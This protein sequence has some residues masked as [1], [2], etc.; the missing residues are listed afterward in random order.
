MGTKWKGWTA[1]TAVKVFAFMLAV[2][3]AFVFVSSVYF[4]I[5][6]YVER[7]V[8]P[9]VVLADLTVSGYDYFFD[10]NIPF[11]EYQ[12][13]VVLNGKNEA[14]IREVINFEWLNDVD[15]YVLY[16]ENT[17]SNNIESY[18][19]NDEEAASPGFRQRVENSILNR[20]ITDLANA[21][22]AL[23]TEE[24]LLFYIS[25]GEFVFTN[26]ENAAIE[27][28]T[29]CPVYRLFEGNRVIAKSKTS[30][31]DSSYN[32]ANTNIKIYVAY[33]N[34]TV[35]SYISNM[36]ISQKIYIRL[37]F[38]AGISVIVAIASIIVLIAGAGRRRYDNG[39]EIHFTAFDWLFLD[40]GIAALLLWEIFAAVVIVDG[41][42]Y[43]ISYNTA[44]NRALFI[45]ALI[46]VLAGIP[47]LGWICSFAKRAKSGN[48]FRHTIAY[49]LFA[50]CVR[51]VRSLW[52][53]VPLTVKAVLVSVVSFIVMAVFVFTWVDGMI[54]LAF[55]ISVGIGILLL[56]YG[57]R[58]RAI[59]IGAQLAGE[60]FYDEPIDVKGGEL[61]KIANSINHISAGINNAVAERMKS[62]RLKTEL[63]TN[64]SHDIRTPLTSLITYT[65][66]LKNEGLDCEKAPEYL[67]VL[68]QKSQRLKTLT[69]E[70]FEASKAA[71]GNIDAN[72]ET[73]NLHAFI[74][75][76]LGEL[77]VRVQS[78]GL[79]FR[80]NI[81][82]TSLVM[83][84]G[85]LLW[86]VMENLL[87]NVFKYAQP[88]SR[89]Y[90]DA[91]SDGDCYRLDVKNMSKYS[92][93]I[94]P[95]ELTE[96]FKRGDEARSGDGSGLGL[97]IVQSFVQAQ[98][99]R[100]VLAVD[101]DLFKATVYLPSVN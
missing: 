37:L 27:T 87:S 29:A 21:Q 91:V 41:G 89:V 56:L 79:D 13:S 28:F 58:L 4:M 22:T 82:E 19:Y 61:G 68:I 53:G 101:G 84:D 81:P 9:E 80:L 42:G 83:A 26:A 31:Y 47:L 12:A 40:I 43:L 14:N 59:E 54:V 60:G 10:N 11:A 38:M 8:N 73:L 17:S 100:F 51:F 64:V 16:A 99:G 94:D 72:P 57:R 46:A 23:T 18:Y 76:V 45:I 35:S 97:S 96:R 48:P 75:Q 90:I 74:E 86:R 98:C 6:E 24:G 7:E 30:G 95:S 69:D 3:S 49:W 92:L 62:E 33:D 85:K 5:R 71:S 63:I 52:A 77:D 15:E 32:S 88:A 20:E 67:E 93:N 34:V 36:Q 66:L 44:N 78:S 50:K 1:H 65:D 25:D 2:L 70:L 55:F 39:R